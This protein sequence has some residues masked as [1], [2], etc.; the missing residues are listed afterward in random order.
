[1]GFN[2][3]RHP[4]KISDRPPSIKPLELD[5]TPLINR[6]S[7]I[8]KSKTSPTHAPKPS[9]SSPYGFRKLDATEPQRQGLKP[10]RLGPVV[11]R[12]SPVPPEM[13]G[14]DRTPPKAPQDQGESTEDLLEHNG[15][16]RSYRLNRDTP[17][18]RCQQRSSTVWPLP[19]A[20][21]ASE[22]DERVITFDDQRAARPRMISRSSSGSLRR[23]PSGDVS[24]GSSISSRPSNERMRPRR[25][26]SQQF[27]RKSGADQD[28]EEL[29]KEVMEL[30]TIVEE[31]RAENSKSNPSDQH[32]AAV[33]PA[34]RVRARAE[35]LDA[36]G[37]AFSRP[38]TAQSHHRAQP[39]DH[40][41]SQQPTLRRSASATLRT[42]SRVSGWLSGLLPTSSTTQLPTTQPFYKCQPR[43]PGLPRTH[44]NT[45]LYSSAS[46]PSSPSLTAASSPTSKGHS[47][48]HTG[49]S[50]ITPLS[51]AMPTT[52]YDSEGTKVEE[53]WPVIMTP[54]SQVGLAL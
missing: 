12:E 9:I 2:T 50:R 51:P 40:S 19:P 16:P 20:P 11:L 25:K 27:S 30:N 31:R 13:Q 42:S 46:D 7:L 45:S 24:S 37:S 39:P 52:C 17:F 43:P 35:T 5:E 8:G 21:A 36:I 15:R 49:E 23:I 34:M 3:H 1:M 28:D 29:E 32:V 38:V 4:S 6:W 33:A 10:L 26:R 54:T 47:R 48:S 22:G 44:S 41:I 18:Q 14:G 53:R